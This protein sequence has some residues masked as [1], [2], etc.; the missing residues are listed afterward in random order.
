MFKRKDELNEEKNMRLAN[1]I[2]K[3]GKPKFLVTIVTY[4]LLISII[5]IFVVL[6]FGLS[7]NITKVMPNF[8]TTLYSESNFYQYDINTLEAAKSQLT[9]H[10]NKVKDEVYNEKD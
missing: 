6:K 2:N 9:S 3:A 4:L 8:R 7:Y 1:G 10:Y 5:V